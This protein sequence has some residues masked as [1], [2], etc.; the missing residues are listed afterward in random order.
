MKKAIQRVLQ[1]LTIRTHSQRELL[2]FVLDEKTIDIA[3]RGSM[4]KRNQL[5]KRVG[6]TR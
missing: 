2:D 4:E 1:R 6:L 3:A 5:L